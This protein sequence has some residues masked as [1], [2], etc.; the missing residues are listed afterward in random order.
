MRFFSPRKW[1]LALSIVGLGLS[2]QPG[3]CAFFSGTGTGSGSGNPLAASADFSYSGGILTIVLTNTS[4]FDY[5]ASPNSSS[6]VPTDVLTGLFFNYNG[7]FGPSLTFNTAT[8][9][10]I[11][12]GSNPSN[13]KLSSTP[14]GWDFAQGSLSGV[15]QHYGL[16][17]AGMGIFDGG[18]SS[19]GTG[20]P[21]NFGI[22]NSLYVDGEGNPSVNGTPY[23]K[24][25]ITFSLSVSGA[26]DPNLISN[27]RFQ[28][29]TN[30][31]EG[32]FSGGGGNL[33]I[34]PAPAG[35][36]LFASGLPVLGLCRLIR[37]KPVAA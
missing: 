25:S 1:V 35:L 29:G 32:D 27:V 16:G 13:L 28:Y 5:K 23:A 20:N 24:D 12:V 6:A 9:P 14:G 30:L 26:F 8:T 15:T 33:L 2:A 36:I 19:G 3:Q 4:G 17:T 21:S 37:R 31:S 22:M 34:T 7:G 10:T 18:T 11:T